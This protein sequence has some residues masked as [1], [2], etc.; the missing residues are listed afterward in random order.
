M[1]QVLRDKK[2]IFAFV[3]PGFIL[4]TLLVILPIVWSGYYSFFDGTAGMKSWAFAGLKNYGK[5][6]KDKNFLNA[7][8]VNMRYVLMVTV[9][10]V[11]FG[12]LM[13]L[14]FKFWVKKFGALVRTIVFF[15]VVLPTVAVAQLFAKIYEI[16]PHYGLLNSVLAGVGLE[17][18]VQPW[19]GKS[20]TALGSL[21]A[22][23]IWVAIGFYSVIIYGALLDISSEVLEA[24]QIDGCNAFQ[25]F[26]HILAPLLR[27]IL[28]TC[29]IFSFT[30]T[31]KMF[32]SAL[33]LTGGG[34]GTATRSLS[35][36]MYDTAFTYMK[37]G[38]GSTIALVIFLICVIGSR[39]IRFFDRDYSR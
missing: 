32:E 13:A 4:Y 19:I 27:P 14:I 10:Q 28:V 34:P 21:A 7:L 3:A 8:S 9:G 30:G 5:L 2:A 18:W 12:L 35:M 22:M 24:A 23:D 16:Q 38:Y 37:T 20:S 33:A 36:Y 11:F 17:S 39:I 1:N 31:V 26:R 29:V 6:F 25:L 15:P